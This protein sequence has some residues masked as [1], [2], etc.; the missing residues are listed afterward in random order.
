MYSLSCFFSKLFFMLLWNNI[1]FWNDFTW[2]LLTKYICKRFFCFAGVSRMIGVGYVPLW[3]AEDRHAYS[4]TYWRLFK[5]EN[6]G[7]EDVSWEWPL[8]Y[9]CCP[10]VQQIPLIV[11]LGCV[12][13]LGSPQWRPT[14]EGSLPSWWHFRPVPLLSELQF[15]GGNNQDNKT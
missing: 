8:L 3:T 15:P 12:A 13:P 10:A 11:W 4:Y 5:E 9:L 14:T 7:L 2:S 6:P 1:I